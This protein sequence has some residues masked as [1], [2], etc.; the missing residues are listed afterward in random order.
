[1]NIVA[2]VLGQILSRIVVGAGSI[3]MTLVFF[4]VLPLIQAISGG[5]LADTMITT[6]DTAELPPPPAAP[7]PEPEPEPE[8]DEPPPEL[9]EESQPLDLSQ[10]EMALD[11]GGFGD[12]F[13]QI[14]SVMKLNAAA[15]GGTVDN[16]FSRA[17]LDQNPR[18][19]IQTAPVFSAKLKKRAPATVKIVFIVDE[20]G[21]VTDPKVQSSTDPA[22]NSAALDA[23]RQWKF[24]PGQRKGESVRFP[25]RVPI[26]F[27]KD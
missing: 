2:K 3:V 12:G 21:R 24:E 15:S 20:R 18:A 14:D 19:L 23:I 17:E 22:F 27:P 10:L 11:P 4:L 7:E 5:P 8:P 1:M 9:A 26:T 6:V 25:M 13:M 16:L